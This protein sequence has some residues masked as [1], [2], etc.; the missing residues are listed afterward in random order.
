M[1]LFVILDHFVNVR[2]QSASISGLT[3]NSSQCNTDSDVDS[4]AL[5]E[6]YNSVVDESTKQNQNDAIAAGGNIIKGGQSSQAVSKNCHRDA[7]TIKSERDYSDLNVLP[8]E[9]EGKVNILFNLK[10]NFLVVVNN[11]RAFQ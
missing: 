10:V 11:K 7:N 2:N 3:L 8:S 6:E 5:G 9:R 1:I 4:I